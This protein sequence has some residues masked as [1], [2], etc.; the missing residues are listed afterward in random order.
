M[1]N[2]RECRN[3]YPCIDCAEKILHGLKGPGYEFGRKIIYPSVS[4]RIYANMQ[5]WLKYHPSEDEII[6]LKKDAQEREK[7]ST[8][9]I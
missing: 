1:D 7:K 5:L 4:N 8:L 6:D 3:K 9:R 2:C